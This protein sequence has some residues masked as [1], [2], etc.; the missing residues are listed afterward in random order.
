MVHKTREMFYKWNTSLPFPP[1]GAEKQVQ[2]PFSEAIYGQ[3]VPNLWFLLSA[4]RF[5]RDKRNPHLLTRFTW[6]GKVTRYSK[7]L[8]ITHYFQDFV[9]FECLLPKYRKIVCHNFIPFHIFNILCHVMY[10]FFAA[11]TVLITTP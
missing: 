9:I 5:P 1:I 7:K 8:F 10:L 3:L 2:H 4:V 6:R 11:W